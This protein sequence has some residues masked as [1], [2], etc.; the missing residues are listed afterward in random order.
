MYN[1]VIRHLCNLR[2]AYP[3]KSSTHVTPY[4]VIT[5]LL[6]IFP[7]LYVASLW[8]FIIGNLYFVFPFARCVFALICNYTWRI[9][10]ITSKSIV[11]FGCLL[12]NMYYLKW[13]YIAIHIQTPNEES[14]ALVSTW[15]WAAAWPWVSHC[16][17][18][19]AVSLSSIHSYIITP[20]EPQHFFWKHFLSILTH[21]VL[22]KLTPGIGPDRLKAIIVSHL[23]GYR[24]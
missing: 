2:S 17:W 16:P 22:C 13:D 24:N 3:S 10:N 19:L 15:P 7:M 11:P 5:I 9:K 6:S 18:T 21:V 8:L 14:W 23:F 1:I 20:T 12:W 4:I